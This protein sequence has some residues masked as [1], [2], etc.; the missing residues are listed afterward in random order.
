[1]NQQEI[2]FPQ[3]KITKEEQEEIDAWIKDFEKAWFEF[4]GK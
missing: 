1:M 2:K 4:S 3:Q